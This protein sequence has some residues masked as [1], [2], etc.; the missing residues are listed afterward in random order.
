MKRLFKYIVSVLFF[1]L[2]FSFSSLAAQNASKVYTES[3]S[4]NVRKTASTSASVIKKLKKN[5][6]I[7]V[8]K[9]SGSF[10]KVEFADGKYGY[11]YA[12]YLKPKAKDE[13]YVSVSSGRLNVRKSADK[14]SK[15]KDKLENGKKV[16]ILSKSGSF[17]KVLYSGTKTGYV[18]SAY[19]KAQKPSYK[20]VNLSVVSFKQTD[21]RWKNLKL[22]SSNDTIGSSG[23]TT[24]ALAMTQSYRTGKTVTPAQMSKTL[25]YSSTGMLYWPSDYNT[26]LVTNSNY[27]K[28]VYDVLKTG[29]PVIL[30]AKTSSGKQHWVVVKGF[31][32]TSL[33]ASEFYIND[34]G[35]SK[36]TKLSHFIADYGTLYKMAW[37]K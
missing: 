28:R 32:G 13:M 7:T 15:I 10:Y 3:S 8:I 31:S 6:W 33:K 5:T 35:S 27:L 37:Y 9:K 30:G 11:C 4:L 25:S 2:L 34:P 14:N 16:L 24:T 18:S 29:K 22:G 20:A 12:D 17:Y 1:V 26:E 36:R 23:C 19:L 21:E